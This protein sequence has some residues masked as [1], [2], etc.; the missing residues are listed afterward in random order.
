MGRLDAAAQRLAVA[1]PSS[2][3]RTPVADRERLIG[4]CASSDDAERQIALRNLCTCHVQADD[5]EVWATLL[6]ML[7]DPS[8]KV[9]TEAVHAVTD[10]TPATRVE[11]VA[12]ALEQRRDDADPKLRRRIRK[13]LA[14]YH[15]TGKL[16]DAAR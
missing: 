15:R 8:P 7:D 3:A 14:H 2:R 13:T 11:T 16:T 5:D 9:R 10:S 4:A 6:H 12:A 1:R